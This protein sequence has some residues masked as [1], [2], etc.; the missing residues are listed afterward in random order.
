M[1]APTVMHPRVFPAILLFAL[2]A[3]AAPAALAVD[4]EDAAGDETRIKLSDE[5]IQRFRDFWHGRKQGQWSNR[6]LGI[7]TLQ[8]PLD[9]WIIQEILFEVK[10]DFVV[11]T[12]TF[13][14]GSAAIWAMFL[15]HINPQ[16]RVIT[17]DIKDIREVGAKSLPIAKRKIDFL[18]GS[19]TDPTI[20]AEVAKRVRGKKVLVILDALKTRDHVLAELRAYAPLVSV[21]SYIIVQDIIPE[22]SLGVRESDYGKKRFQADQAVREFLA[23]NDD[24]RIDR[25]R[26]RQVITN[27]VGGF[28]KRIE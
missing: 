5:E 1:T 8:N 4:E 28:L 26:E 16:A 19:S 12:G 25:K 13:H 22:V 17:M 27:I 18:L 9:V 2:L 10:P 20:V 14:G 11:E 15:E 3:A 6:F 24:F 7:W 21:G 23:S